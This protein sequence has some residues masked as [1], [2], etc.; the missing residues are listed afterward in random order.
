M[1]KSTF[2]ILFVIQRGK[3]NAKGFVPILA[4]IT[5][6]GEMCHFSTKITI[7]P[8]RWLA[9]E[10]RTVGTS[11]E[12]K[13]INE[14]LKDFEATSKRLYNQMI[15]RGEIP[16]A[17]KIRNSIMGLDEK[18]MKFVELADK[19][20][21][22]YRRLVRVNNYGQESLDRYELLRRRLAEYLETECKR[23]DI[24]LADVNHNFLKE[25]FLWFRE[26]K[27]LSNNTAT[28]TMHR[29][30]TIFKVARDNGWVSHNPFGSLKMHFDKV[31]RGYLTQEELNR[32]LHKTF[33]TE[34]LTLI[35]DLF[36]FSCYTGLAY[37]DVARLTKEMVE[38]HNDG[39]LWICTCRQK[40][41]VPVNI[42]LLDIP[43]MIIDKY[44]GQTK[45]NKLLP[46]PSNQKM[47]DYL[48]EIAAVCGIDKSISYHMARHTFATQI[49][50]SNGVPIESVSK[51]LGHT[52]IKTT[53]I[54]A[55]ITDQKVS[56]DMEVL[57]KKL[58][59]I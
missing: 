44:A 41:K 49:C 4:R 23:K 51:M 32:I 31:D 35:R 55:R 45:G 26:Q 21:D 17:V 57:A 59:C 36:V 52:N 43:K 15:F 14:A 50:L 16:N 47:N 6:N 9:K 25:L 34:R 24:P 46:V 39:T 58:N 1:V 37:V 19:F 12:E 38:E 22:D 27:K 11:L 8:D 42:R 2:K 20:I 56:N 33:T 30:S 13:Q 28:K 29:L 48:K 10:G 7:Q 53:Q 40:T 18:S 3:A 5:I 54:Y